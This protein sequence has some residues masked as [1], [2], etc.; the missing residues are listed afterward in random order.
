M[1]DGIL[2]VSYGGGCVVARQAGAP[3]GNVPGAVLV[4]NT[5]RPPSR[6]VAISNEGPTVIEARA[7]EPKTPVGGCHRERDPGHRQSR[8]HGNSLVIGKA[9]SYQEGTWH[10]WN[11][12]LAAK[13]TR[14]KLTIARHVICR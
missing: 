11:V 14:R 5:T 13:P 12:L 3:A 9:E 2:H 6:M 1:P 4:I 7:G 8:L 10:L